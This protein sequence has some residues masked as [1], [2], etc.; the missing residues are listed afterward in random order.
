[1]LNMTFSVSHK[2]MSW[3]LEFGPDNVSLE[4]HNFADEVALNSNE[5]PLAVWNL[6]ES[7]GQRLLEDAIAGAPLTEGEQTRPYEL[8]EQANVPNLLPNLAMCQYAIRGWK[9][10]E[11]KNDNG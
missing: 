10:Q 1:M 8:H 9:G 6:L 2:N 3:S 7:Q 4:V 11:I 5:I